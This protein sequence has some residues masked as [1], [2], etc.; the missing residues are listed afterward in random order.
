MKKI[1]TKNKSE[2]DI[3]Y[4]AFLAHQYSILQYHSDPDYRA[5]VETPKFQELINSMPKECTD[6]NH[7]EWMFSEKHLNY[8]FLADL[9]EQLIENDK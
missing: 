6:K 7:P 3:E 9:V 1:T 4:T 8:Q 2:A 5:M